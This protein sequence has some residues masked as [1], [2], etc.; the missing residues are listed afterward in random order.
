MYNSMIKL[1][2]VVDILIPGIIQKSGEG[3][4]IFII[5]QVDFANSSFT[6]ECETLTISNNFKNV[7][8]PYDILV[9]KHASTIFKVAII[10]EV[11]NTLA[12]NNELFII[13]QKSKEAIKDNSISLYM[14]LKSDKG[15]EELSKLSQA[16]TIKSISKVVLEEIN[17]PV[18]ADMKPKIVE[19]FY[20][21]HKLYNDIHG[22]SI[23][24]NKIHQGFGSS[25]K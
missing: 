10:G 15:Q 2:E 22:I 11:Q 3:D 5:S 24:I 1:K 21:E 25:K 14:Y 23:K 8:Q 16:A 4:K 7:L 18:F 19:N 12:A 20:E 9:A 13:R 17:I 6:T